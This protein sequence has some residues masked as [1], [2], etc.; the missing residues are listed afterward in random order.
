L[1][2]DT[3]ILTKKYIAVL[4]IKNIRGKIYFQSNPEQLIRE[5]DGETTSFKCPE[6]QLKRHIKKLQFLLQTFK[7]NI[8]I[9]SL[10][11]LAYSQTQVALPPKLTK[12]VMGCDIS[13][14]LDN[15]NQLP[16]TISTVKFHQILN[17]LISHTHEFIPNPLTQYFSI[18]TSLIRTGLFCPNCLIKMKG[19]SKCLRCKTPKTLM[20]KQ[21]IEDWFYLVKNTISNREC[22]YFLELKDKYAAN[23]LLNK[24][25]L[26]PVNDFKS[27][28]YVLQRN[29]ETKS[30]GR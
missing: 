24:L 11:V 23:Y 8:P 18:N 29:F 21:A 22:V 14:E 9:K 10:I 30:N 16:D 7:V 20:Q 6:Q 25:D 15:Y 3:L 1:Q 2:I 26:R 28:H 4:E 27:R 12:I 19:Q 17:F 13:A 5:V